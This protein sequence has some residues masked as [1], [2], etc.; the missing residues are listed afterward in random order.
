MAETLRA[1][2]TWDPASVL[3]GNFSKKAITVTGAVLGDMVVASFDVDI[4]DLQLTASVVGD[5]SVE[6]ILTNST[7]GTLDIG[8]GTLRVVVTSLAGLN[9][10]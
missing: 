5:D 1:S 9:A 8:S 7:D 4:T 3:D 6:A 10:S 2:V